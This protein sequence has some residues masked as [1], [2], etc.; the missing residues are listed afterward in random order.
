[1]AKNT[2]I[3]LGKHF[4]NFIQQ[5]IDEG[6]YNNASEMIRA[7][8]RLLEQEEAKIIALRKAIR[9]GLN[10]EMVEDFD[11]ELFL[12]QLKAKENVKT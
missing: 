4:E 12:R 8:L 9:E 11:P 3:S 5:G 1:M 6:R 10:S 2:S 7:G